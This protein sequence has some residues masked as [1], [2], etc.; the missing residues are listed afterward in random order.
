MSLM[1]TV[2]LRTTAPG[3]SHAAQVAAKRELR[4]SCICP[5]SLEHDPRGNVPQKKVTQKQTLTRV[6]EEADQWGKKVGDD[7]A[8]KRIPPTHI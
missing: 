1:P 8:R 2:M 6:A 3:H 5:Y 7:V 4:A